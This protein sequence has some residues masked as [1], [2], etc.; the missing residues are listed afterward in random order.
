MMDRTM[1]SACHPPNRLQGFQHLDHPQLLAHHPALP[2]LE[3]L[4]PQIGKGLLST[5][6]A[7]ELQHSADDFSSSQLPA[8]SS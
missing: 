6:S 3:L 1:S 7:A 2:V 8:A 4:D 5:G